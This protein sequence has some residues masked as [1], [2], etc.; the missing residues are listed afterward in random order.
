MIRYSHERQ[1]DSEAKTSSLGLN[2]LEIYPLWESVIN[3][4][5]TDLGI[6]KVGTSGSLADC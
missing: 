6:E 2:M 3:S 5:K 4:Q 1:G